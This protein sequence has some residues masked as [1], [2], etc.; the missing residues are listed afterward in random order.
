MSA[1]NPSASALVFLSTKIDICLI[2]STIFA[3][4]LRSDADK[5]FKLDLSNISFAL[6][7]CTNKS[8]YQGYR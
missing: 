4:S 3:A 2:A 8:Y 6:L 7:G 1:I 5:I